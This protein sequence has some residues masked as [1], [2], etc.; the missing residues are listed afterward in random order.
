MAFSGIL[1]KIVHAFLVSVTSATC[2][3]PGFNSVST[4]CNCVINTC[5]HVVT[6]LFAIFTLGYQDPLVSLLTVFLKCI[7]L[8]AASCI[9]FPHINVDFCY[10]DGSELPHALDEIKSGLFYIFEIQRFGKDYKIM[11]VLE[12]NNNKNLRNLLLS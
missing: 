1:I 7:L 2:P 12:L 3:A 10:Y 6:R 5:T 8:K 9:L 11:I 4:Y